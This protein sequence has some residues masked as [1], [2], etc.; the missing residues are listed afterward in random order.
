MYYEIEI[1]TDNEGNDSKGIYTYETRDEAVSV[2]HKKQGSGMDAGRAGN[3]TKVLN[4]VI[5][6]HGGTETKEFWQAP[7]QPE[8]EPEPEV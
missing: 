8:P 7:V 4:L 1:Q 5:N 2:F 6:E 3:L